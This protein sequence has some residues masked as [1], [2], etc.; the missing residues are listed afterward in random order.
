MFCTDFT[1]K[2]HRHV[3]AKR[4]SVAAWT[5][6]WSVFST[7]WSMISLLADISSNNQ[8]Q[9][10]RIQQQQFQ[11]RIERQ[12]VRLEDKIDAVG[13]K[14]DEVSN[15]VKT[16]LRNQ[17]WNQVLINYADDVQIVEALVDQFR[18]DIYLR[19]S[20]FLPAH[21]AEAWAE[22]V[23]S[24]GADGIDQA[25]W[26][27]HNMVMGGNYFSGG[28]VIVVFES[29]LDRD[30]SAY[31]T[32]L[33][34]FVEYTVSLQ[35][36]GYGMW[37]SAL[38]IK[39]HTQSMR[40]KVRLMEDRIAEQKSFLDDI[41]VFWPA[42]EWGLSKTNTGCP[43]HSG[44]TWLSGS[45]YHDTEDDNNNNQKSEPN[46]FPSVVD[47]NIA[48]EFCMKHSGGRGHWPAGDYC[49]FR[50]S[51]RC[52]WGFNHGS[53]YW[54]DE[55]DGNTNF[56]YGTLPSGTYDKNTLIRYCCRHDGSYLQDIVLPTAKPFYLFE[57]RGYCQKVIL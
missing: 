44:F 56:F 7:A 45:R 41:A 2:V 43:A 42:G 16:L 49:I 18:R 14:I 24:R 10:D 37:V 46:H 17:R 6:G 26:N 22:A 27:L 8:Q 30:S 57:N 15:N 11:E 12:L 25:L 32:R 3:I 34:Q 55:D 39:G 38:Q 5:T 28:P 52:P 9:Q 53:I 54:D 20:Q 4:F 29:L 48:Q 36:A 33:H 23:L 35:I 31:S 51:D 40:S 50:S 19:D 1:D 13:N 47:K 21:D